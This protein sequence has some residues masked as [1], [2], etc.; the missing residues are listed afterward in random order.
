MGEA[1]RPRRFRGTIVCEH[2]EHI[3]LFFLGWPAYRASLKRPLSA[4]GEDWAIGN[5]QIAYEQIRVL[6]MLGHKIHIIDQ[7]EDL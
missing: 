5:V 6:E 7:S 1:S 4:R 3:A 2:D